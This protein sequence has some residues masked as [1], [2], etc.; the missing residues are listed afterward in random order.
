M[1]C[2]CALAG[3]KA[4]RTCSNNPYADDLSSI[5]TPVINTTGTYIIP[6]KVYEQVNP[7]DI[8]TSEEFLKIISNLNQHIEDLRAEIKELKERGE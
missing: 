8:K 5:T 1:V 2:C 4:C 3:T 6:T 7:A